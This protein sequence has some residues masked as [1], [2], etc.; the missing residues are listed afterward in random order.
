MSKNSISIIIIFMLIICITA[1]RK[2]K[3]TKRR[4]GTG[5]ETYFDRIEAKLMQKQKKSTDTCP[6]CGAPLTSEICPYCGNKTGLDTKHT[7]MEYPSIDCKE[8]NIGFWTV[9]FPGIFAF[10][11]TWFGLCMPIFFILTGNATEWTEKAV[12]VLFGILFG[13]VGIGAHIVMLRPII[14]Y[15]RVKL[16]GKMITGTVY[17]YLDDNV[18]MNGAPAQVVKILVQTRKGPRFLLYQLGRT[19]RP[20][21]INSKVTLEVYKD[22]Y[23]LSRRNDETD[24]LWEIKG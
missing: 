5:A 22:M 4:V 1:F 12:L 23:L 10:T 3:S 7:D 16:H 9:M 18:I 15:L 19:N 13:G 11:F 24:E 2:R 8:A 20:Y 21:Q 17:G 6:H 14:S